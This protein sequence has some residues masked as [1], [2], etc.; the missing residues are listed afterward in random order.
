[1]I[2][3]SAM[4]VMLKANIPV[5]PGNATVKNGTLSSTMKSIL[6]ELKPEAAYFVAENGMRTAI[7]FLGIEDSSELPKLAEPFF[8]AFNSSV[9]VVPC[10]NADDLSRAGKHLEAAAKKYSGA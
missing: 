1:M 2:A 9:E 3:C 7:L 4:R 5:E 10:M 6:E 8:L